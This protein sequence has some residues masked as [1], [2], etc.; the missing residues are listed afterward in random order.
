MTASAT[1]MGF[2]LV[3][4][5]PPW[6]RN[7]RCSIALAKVRRLVRGL[8]RPGPFCNND[9]IGR[10][11]TPMVLFPFGVTMSRSNN[12]AA[13]LATQP[14]YMH[15]KLPL[16]SRSEEEYLRRLCVSLAVRARRG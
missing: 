8:T 9:H 4:N 16:K 6:P 14:T 11:A 13:H 7:G 2:S 3:Q 15:S 5:N 1:L 12:N 10:Q